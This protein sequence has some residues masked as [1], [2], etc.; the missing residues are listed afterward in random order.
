MLDIISPCVTF[1]NHEESTKSY[2]WGKEHETPLNELLRLRA[3]RSR[4]SRIGDY[5]GEIEVEMHD[6]S[7]IVLKKLDP[8]Y[9]PTNKATA[10]RVLEEAR[11]QAEVHHRP[12]LRQRRRAARTCSSCS[13]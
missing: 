5:E 4:R 7:Q 8:D 9:D 2:S 10:F 3:L 11:A 6:S 13:S 12:D 1:N